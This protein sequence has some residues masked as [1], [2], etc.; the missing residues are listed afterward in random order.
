MEKYFAK[1]KELG[2]KTAAGE[3][4]MQRRLEEAARP[5]GLGDVSKMQGPPIPEIPK[6]ELSPLQQQ[7]IELYDRMQMFNGIKLD[8]FGS[9]LSALKTEIGEFAFAG[10]QAFA[11]FFADLV[12]GQENAGKKFL[13]A[14]M[15]MLGK[16]LVQL[17]SM[18]VSLG[19]SEMVLASSPFTAMI[20][21]SSHAH[22][23]L[24]VAKGI[25]IAAAGGIMMGASSALAQTNQSGAAGNSFQ[26]DIARPTTSQQVQVINVGAAGRAQSAAQAAAYQPVELRVK[27]ESNDSHIVRVVEKNVSDNGR[28]R[29][30]IQNA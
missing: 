9:V 2:Q 10:T 24:L 28:L 14:L 21:G 3:A 5:Q 22:G 4:E 12:S 30:V 13:A 7:M 20:T 19:I 8:G 11:G 29:T 25:A 6:V 15:G 27:V 16:T 26:Q 23:A 1:V 18:M 17:G